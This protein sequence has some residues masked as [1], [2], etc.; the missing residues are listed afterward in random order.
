M[1]CYNFVD[2]KSK[3]LNYMVLTISTWR[4]MCILFYCNKLPWSKIKPCNMTIGFSIGLHCQA[5]KG[6]QMAVCSV[7]HRSAI[8]HV[9]IIDNNHFK[10]YPLGCCTNTT[11]SFSMHLFVFFLFK[12][13]KNFRLFGLRAQMQIEQRG[14]TN[15]QHF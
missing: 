8:G 14:H 4:I 9:L 13:V 5:Q 12:A 2:T 7:L 3:P 1:F 6:H 10:C 11:P 15:V